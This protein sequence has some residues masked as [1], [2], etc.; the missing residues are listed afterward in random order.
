MAAWVKKEGVLREPDQAAIVA[1][2]GRCEPQAVKSHGS[3]EPLRERLF[4]VMWE[5][6]GI[7]RDAAGLKSALSELS[8]ISDQLA[9]TGI[10]DTNRAFNLTWHDWLNLRSLVA[11]SQVIAQAALARED[12]RGAHFREDF[13]AAGPLETS[14]YTSARFAGE[15]LEISMQPVSFSRVRPGQSLL[16]RDL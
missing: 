2:V 4:D 9:N 3:L 15:R 16:V 5:K 10:A 8:A 7:I 11:T 6:V 13:P 14:S 1:A 12:S